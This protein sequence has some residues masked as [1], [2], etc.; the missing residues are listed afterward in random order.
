MFK[1][2]IVHRQSLHVVQDFEWNVFNHV[3]HNSESKLFWNFMY[4]I[5]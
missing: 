5:M 1:Y 3:T 2:L 4:A